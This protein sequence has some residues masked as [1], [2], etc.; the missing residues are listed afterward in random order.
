MKWKVFIGVLM[1]AAVGLSVVEFVLWHCPDGRMPR[2]V[3][4]APKHAQLLSAAIQGKSNRVIRW[5]ILWRYGRADRDIGLLYTIEEWDLPGGV[6]TMHSEIGPSFTETSCARCWHLLD[7]VNPLGRCMLKSYEL[8]GTASGKAFALGELKL[9]PD[10][11]YS[12]ER[13]TVLPPGEPLPHFFFMDH[14]VG[15][16]EIHYEPGIGAET[17]LEDLS[18]DAVVARITFISSE[19]VESDG[20]AVG[21]NS[22]FR[23]LEMRSESPFAFRAATWVVDWG[24]RK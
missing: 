13:R 6:L 19:G 14:P 1:V 21:Y 11:T 17:L 16:T 24:V 9:N 18:R 3:R 2:A 7:T 23:L 20:F 22:K 12:Y 8:R 10:T 5:A 4:D 15:K